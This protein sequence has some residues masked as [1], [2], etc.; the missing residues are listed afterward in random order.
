MNRQILAAI[1]VVI[2]IFSAVGA[3]IMLRPSAE[4]EYDI[5]I[6]YSQKVNYETIMVADD[7]GL[8]E[9]QGLNVTS[10]IV[11]G[12]IQA[13]EALIT[14]SADLAAMGDAPAVQLMTRDTG[15]KIVARFIG[16]AGMHRFIAWSDIV[17]PTD[18]EG[19]KV[20][21]QQG[22]STHGAFLQWCQANDVNANNITFVFMNPVDI[23]LA[24][25][26]RQIDAM[27]GS[28]PWAVNTENLCGDDVHEIGNSSEV[29]STFPI[30]L[31]ASQKA[32]QEKGEAIERVLKALD[33]ANQFIVENWDGAMQD[34]ANHTGLSIADQSN[35]SGVQFY[36]VGFNATDVQSMTMTAMTLLDFGKIDEVPVIM[37]NV[38]LSYL[39]ED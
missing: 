23:P 36:Q 38:D 9:D 10:K 35:C 39:P 11:T 17:Q 2:V 29:G 24:M 4:K 32:L 25:S 5:T 37:D 13:A 27:A 14:A 8:F 12:G 28:E 26:T 1:V 34:C 18:L 21:L 22:S 16:G 19:L 31:V 3:V 20:G 15:A 6:A 30:V 33:Q 7:E